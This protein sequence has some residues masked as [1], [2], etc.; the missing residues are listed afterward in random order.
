MSM[1]LPEFVES[2]PLAFISAN[3]KGKCSTVLYKLKG[4]LST[5]SRDPSPQKGLCVIAVPAFLW[6][7]DVIQKPGW[8]I[9]QVG[10]PGKKSSDGVIYRAVGRK[11][12]VKIIECV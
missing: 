5:N 7:Y 10:D 6:H 3:A 4:E 11:I 1:N 8:F 9:S 12:F 2:F